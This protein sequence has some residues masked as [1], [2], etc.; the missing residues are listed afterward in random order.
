M[1]DERKPWEQIEG[2]PIKWYSRFDKLRLMKPWKRSINAVYVEEQDVKKGEKTRENAPTLWYDIAKQWE[3]NGRAEAWDKYRITERDKQIAA[4]EE[5]I[6]KS[7]Y[8]LKH[9]RI[10]DLN[11]IAKLLR[12]EVFDDDKRWVDDIKAVGLE[13]HYLKQ[14][15]DS[16]VREYRAA[17]DDIAKE[18]GERAKLTK[19]EL[20]GKDGA[21]LEGGTIIILPDNGRDP[22]VKEDQ[23]E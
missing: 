12:E 15:N 7:E 13:A 5:E 2:E 4:E 9:E 14:F 11:E 23:S 3:W 17:L 20:T 22:A 16:L 10:K 19:S 21:P 8:A 1:D 18:K 6:L